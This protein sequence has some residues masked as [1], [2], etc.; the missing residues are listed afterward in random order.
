[1]V[2]WRAVPCRAAT[3][4]GRACDRHGVHVQGPRRPDPI[5][6]RLLSRI[7]SAPGGEICVCDITGDDVNVTGPH[8]THHLKL[9]REAGLVDGE[10]RGT[11]VRCRLIHDNL[12]QLG[13]R[14]EVSVAVPGLRP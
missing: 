7:T 4:A 3:I 13:A 10:R 14:L 11:W 12:R 8:I 1:M 2:V 9:L 5:R 6:L